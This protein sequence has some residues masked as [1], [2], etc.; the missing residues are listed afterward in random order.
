MGKEENVCKIDVAKVITGV[1]FA[2]RQLEEV[3]LEIEAMMKWAQAI[4]RH[5]EALKKTVQLQR[6]ILEE[7]SGE[8]GA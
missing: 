1:D 6:K 7:V 8:A 3:E 4:L 2:R 5:A